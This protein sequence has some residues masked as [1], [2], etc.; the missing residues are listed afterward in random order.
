MVLTV[1]F[2]DIN[3]LYIYLLDINNL[4]IHKDYLYLIQRP[5]PKDYFTRKSKNVFIFHQFS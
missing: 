2:K 5:L 1:C 3:N 4:Y